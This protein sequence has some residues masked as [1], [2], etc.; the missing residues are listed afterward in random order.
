MIF[1]F[2][3]WGRGDFARF[4]PGENYPVRTHFLAKDRAGKVTAAGV[5]EV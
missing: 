2:I 4:L 1:T 3:Q 5:F